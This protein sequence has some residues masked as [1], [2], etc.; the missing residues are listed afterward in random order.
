MRAR[1][2]DHSDS[3]NDGVLEVTFSAGAGY[4]FVNGMDTEPLAADLARELEEEMEVTW[5]RQPYD[6]VEY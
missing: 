2:A 6:G 1:I 5:N 3:N 4:F